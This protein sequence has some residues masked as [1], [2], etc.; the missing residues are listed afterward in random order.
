MSGVR[1]MTSYPYFATAEDYGCGNGTSLDTYTSHR[2]VFFTKKS[3]TWV[4]ITVDSRVNDSDYDWRS[5]CVANNGPLFCI[6]TLDSIYGWT[7]YTSSNEGATWTRNVVSWPAGTDWTATYTF[8]LSFAGGFGVSLNGQG[9]L[10]SPDGKT[11][12]LNEYTWSAYSLYTDDIEWCYV[13]IYGTVHMT[14]YDEN[15]HVW[16]SSSNDLARW[17]EPVEIIST[18]TYPTE[19]M[20]LV[21]RGDIILVASMNW[22]DYTIDLSLSI[23]A[24]KTWEETSI[25]L[26]AICGAGGFNTWVITHRLSLLGGIK[27]GSAYLFFSWF[28]EDL[29]T[30]ETWTLRGIKAE[31]IALGELSWVQIF[32]A[33]PT[34]AWWFAT[35][36]SDPAGNNMWPIFGGYSWSE[37]RIDGHIYDTYVRT[38]VEMDTDTGLLTDIYSLVG[39]TGDYVMYWLLQNYS[40]SSRIPSGWF[41][42]NCYREFSR[43]GF[44]YF[45]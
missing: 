4:E 10:S 15:Y 7:T 19:G 44:A 38:F 5:V 43:G 1:D 36:A 40:P 17:A 31:N 6:L 23:N 8:I 12:V 37:Q 22:D 42:A 32:N 29:P 35:S 20:C 16:Y 41:V 25:N 34:Q 13:D 3:G 11:W 28:N 27:N 14:M 21:G 18:M 2:L 26:S 9:W 33:W 39:T 24:G 30:T 45:F